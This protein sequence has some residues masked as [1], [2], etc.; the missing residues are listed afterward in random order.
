MPDESRDYPGDR[1]VC[2]VA[3]DPAQPHSR[4]GVATSFYSCA[5]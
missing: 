1:L 2:S 5:I 4:F 3:F